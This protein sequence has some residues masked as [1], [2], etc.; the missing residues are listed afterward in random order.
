MNSSHLPCSVILA[1]HGSTATLESNEPL[2]ELAGQLF[3]SGIFSKV[4]PAFLMGEPQLNSVFAELP[5]G[6]VVIIPVMTSDGYYLR[7]VIPGRIAQ[8]S[9]LD[10]F[11]IFMSPPL[12]THP[13]LAPLVVDRIETLFELLG[14]QAENTAILIIGHGT[15]RSPESARSTEQLASRVRDSFSGLEILTAYIDQDP[16]IETAIGQTNKPNLL[17]IPF[18]ISRG[19]HATVDVPEALGLPGGPDVEFPLVDLLG[20]GLMICDLP[21]GMY[22]E[23]AE[24]CIG[25]A[26][27]QLMLGKPVKF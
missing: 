14:L 22:P 12:G 4:T 5:P 17:A 3:D 1:A 23:V 20:Q 24:L 13:D 19:P 9:S 11:R 6:D 10:L 27:D 2:F 16:T 26:A 8:N 25:L 15:R 21:V 18:L 7:Q